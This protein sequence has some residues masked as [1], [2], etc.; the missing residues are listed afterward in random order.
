M[1]LRTVRATAT[2]SSLLVAVTLGAFYIR[3]YRV[4]DLVALAHNGP[5]VSRVIYLTTGPGELLLTITHTEGSAG[6]RAK[7]TAGVDRETPGLHYKWSL[8][9]LGS[10]I[11]LGW[12]RT[13]LSR[14]GFLAM[15]RA[16][17]FGQ[18]TTTRRTYLA[19]PF[20]F[21]LLPFALPPV[22]YLLRRHRLWARIRRGL[23]AHCGYNI[24]TTPTQCP[25]CG[26]HP[27]PPAGGRPLLTRAGRVALAAA[28]LAI[29]TAVT[30]GG[31]PL[32]LP[33]RVEVPPLVAAAR[34]PSTS[35][36]T[37]T[38][39]SFR[40]VQ[41][42]VSPA[43]GT[44]S[45][46]PSYVFITPAHRE[47]ARQVDLTRTYVFLG[48]GGRADQLRHKVACVEMY[49]RIQG[50][51]RREIAYIPVGQ[52]IAVPRFPCDLR[53]HELRQEAD[54]LVAVFIDPNGNKIVRSANADST[55]PTRRFLSN[56]VSDS[57]RA[58]EGVL[59]PPP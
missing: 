4:G 8:E 23:C 44:R 28:C 10:L 53:V 33:V 49:A 19:A 37:T 57:R 54:D 21:V 27:H 3:S 6:T 13:F 1:S 48:G 58:I 7:T 34:P 36:A 9:P 42:P 22:L 24:R 16:P 55:D 14:R 45:T 47:L 43:T 39:G 41:L 56:I 15:S 25:E 51:W 32:D 5:T 38:A 20:W 2:A 11:E 30:L 35:P 31:R 52:P 59:F 29:A 26:R 40:P 46:P 17:N 50:H 12:E 18:T